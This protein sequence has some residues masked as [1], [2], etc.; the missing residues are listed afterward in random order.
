MKKGRW[1]VAAS[2]AALVSTGVRLAASPIRAAAASA[3]A[4]STGGNGAAAAMASSPL[5]RQRRRSE[6]GARVNVARRAGAALRSNNALQCES[7]AA[8]AQSREKRMS[9]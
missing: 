1:P 6:G 9:A 8:I 4:M 3:I 7:N 5:A 2:S